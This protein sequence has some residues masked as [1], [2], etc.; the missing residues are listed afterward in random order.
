MRLQDIIEDEDL[1]EANYKKANFTDN[2]IGFKVADSSPCGLVICGDGAKLSTSEV[3]TIITCKTRTLRNT[4][5]A[6][7]SSTL[8]GTLFQLEHDFQR[9]LSLI[10]G[11]LDDIKRY[12]EIF[13]IKVIRGLKNLYKVLTVD[14]NVNAQWWERFFGP[15]PEGQEHED[16]VPFHKAKVYFPST[17][18]KNRKKALLELL[19]EIREPFFRHGMGDVI[20]GE[21]RFVKIPSSVLGWY[22]PKTRDIKIQPNVREGNQVVFTLLHEFC[23]KLYFEFLSHDERIELGKKFWDLTGEERGNPTAQAAARSEITGD[24]H[25][26]QALFYSGRMKKL[27]R[28]GKVWEITKIQSDNIYV[29]SV[30]SIEEFGPAHV[31]S[32]I[33]N[34]N[35]LANGDWAKYDKATEVKTPMAALSKRDVKT[36]NWFPTDYSKKNAEEWFAESMALFLIGNLSGDPQTYF[37][38][39]AHT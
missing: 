10:P 36:D 2:I 35:F 28:F 19:E 38:Q 37:G 8:D 27:L 18:Q 32:F 29:K 15:V 6:Y 3:F 33:L 34:R 13:T 17:M 4:V 20:S 26:G 39:F 22:M 5:G 12:P 24:L 30:D 11:K 16:F 25:P 21:I 1:V 9:R 14:L 7:N 31:P 23:H